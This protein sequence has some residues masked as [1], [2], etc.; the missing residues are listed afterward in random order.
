[1]LSAVQ[2]ADLFLRDGPQWNT[3]MR[4]NKGAA[5]D[6]RLIQPAQLPRGMTISGYEFHGPVQF[7][8]I[9]FPDDFTFDG[10][11]FMDTVSFSKATLGSNFRFLSPNFAKLPDLAQAIFSEGF[12]ILNGSVQFLANMHKVTF[13]RGTSFSNFVF[14]KGLDFSHCTFGPNSSFNQSAV[15]EVANFANV[16][17]GD[18]ASFRSAHFMCAPSFE[19]ATF[20]GSVTFLDALLDQGINFRVRV[21]DGYCGFVNTTFGADSH[22]EK[23][24]FRG[25]A[26]FST[27]N[28]GSFGA[29]WFDGA[30]FSEAANFNGRKFLGQTSFRAARFAKPPRFFEATLHQDTDLDADYQGRN[31]PDAERCFRAL[32]LVMSKYQAHREELDFFALEM[33]ARRLKE[34]SPAVMWL[35]DTYDRYSDYGRSVRRPVKALCWVVA[36]S[37]FLYAYINI[38]LTYSSCLPT[39]GCKVVIDNGQLGRLL[40]FTLSQSLPFIRDALGSQASGLPTEE[41]PSLIVRIIAF[42]QGLFSLILLF[43]VGLGLRNLFRLK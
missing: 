42:F 16:T 40:S 1:M 35:Y 26:E 20:G 5:V 8:G 12:T 38:V 34:K 21:V 25:D 13:P 24:R 11:V 17:F 43:L 6:L 23:A 10:C 30:R 33:E 2:C 41:L 39:L 18:G 37:F 36:V 28:L 3:V 32:K 29:I 4:Q 7:D 15:S 14:S 22:F 31:A 19:L 9:T 27:T